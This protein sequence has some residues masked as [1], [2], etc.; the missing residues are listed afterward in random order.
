[1][2]ARRR[3]WQTPTLVTLSELAVIG[4]PASAVSRE[5]L[6]YASKQ[7]R[8][9]WAAN[10]SFFVKRPEI[11]DILKRLAEVA[12]VATRDMASAGVGILAGCDA[13]IPGFCVQDELAAMVRAGMTPLAALQ[14]AT[15]NPAR[16]LGREKTIGSVAPGTVANL[17]LLDANPLDDIAN[18]GNSCSLCGGP[19]GGQ[20]GTGRDPH[21]GAERGAAVILQPFYFGCCVLAVDGGTC[22][23]RR[24]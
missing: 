20:E 13:L 3:V 11:V 8:D 7:L 22:P 4:T 2:F 10:Q 1:M 21:A 15:I 5:H 6:A 12:M 16:Y 9:L 24:I 19:N 23:F 18:V 17:V 14:T